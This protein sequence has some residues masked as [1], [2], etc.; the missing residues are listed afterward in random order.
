MWLLPSILSTSHVS[1]GTARRPSSTMARLTS[2]RGWT[3]EDGTTEIGCELA[4]GHA[5]G[6]SDANINYTY[7]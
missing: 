4:A 3:A 5:G 6:P 7:L 1:Y 2:N